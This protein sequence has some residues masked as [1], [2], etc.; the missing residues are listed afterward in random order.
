MSRMELVYRGD[1]GHCQD[2]G[3]PTR[4]WPPAPGT[5][6]WFM[7]RD[8]V[9]AAAAG[10]AWTDPLAPDVQR[11]YLCVGCLEGRLGR[12]LVPA[13]FM[14]P[15]GLELG[16]EVSTVRLLDRAYGSA[17]HGVTELRR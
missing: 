12:R 16:D 5:W 7:V 1:H 17:V 4:P 6:E 14:G 2:C 13:D 9:W 11:F 15:P 3:H 8:D 10:P